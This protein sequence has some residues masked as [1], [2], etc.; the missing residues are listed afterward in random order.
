MLVLQSAP[1]N[2]SQGWELR[3]LYEAFINRFPTFVSLVR[4][5]INRLEGPSEILR[6]ILNVAPVPYQSWGL[7]SFF[8][9]RGVGGEVG[10]EGR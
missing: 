7:W 10:L 2:G 5:L 8:G 4:I 1:T 3:I 6:V 9:L